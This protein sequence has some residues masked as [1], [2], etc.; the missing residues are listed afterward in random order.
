MRKNSGRPKTVVL[1]R[2]KKSHVEGKDRAL[3]ADQHPG[4]AA[5]RHQHAER[6]GDRVGTEADDRDGVDA[7]E[8]DRQATSVTTAARARCPSRSEISSANSAEEKPTIE[9]I[10]RSTTPASSAKPE[11]AP[12]ISGTTRKVPMIEMLP[13]E[14]NFGP[15]QKQPDG[16]HRD[17]G[18]GDRG[19][20]A[21]QHVA[22]RGCCTTSGGGRTGG[23][24]IG[25]GVPPPRAVA[26]DRH[27][28]DQDQALEDRLGVRREPEEHERGRDGREEPDAEQQHPE[29]A[30]P[31]GQRDARQ[32]HRGDDVELQGV[33]GARVERA[34][35]WR[36]T[37]PRRS[38]RSRPRR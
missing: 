15:T 13:N 12:T 21:G 8:D 33:A 30:A 19:D 29:I 31:A 9:P 36:R 37:A 7:A 34:G 11:K 38:R 6:R 5:Q 25:H 14:R 32:D 2:P 1:T 10:E 22:D 18:E 27:R 4:D 26:V 23:G 28:D 17:E 20:R 16:D 24:G 35:R 3:R